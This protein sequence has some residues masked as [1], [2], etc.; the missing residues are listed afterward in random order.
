VATLAKQHA[1]SGCRADIAIAPRQGHLLISAADSLSSNRHR[2]FSCG[3]DARRSR[4]WISCA[5]NLSGNRRKKTCDLSRLAFN[6]GTKNQRLETE[7]ERFG[8]CS[9]SE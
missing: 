7:S 1:R 3:K 4:D 9:F 8:G 5:R 2:C 6:L